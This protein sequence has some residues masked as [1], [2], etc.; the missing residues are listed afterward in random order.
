MPT[1]LLGGKTPFEL[2]HGKPPCYEYLRTFGCLCFVF[3]L[4]QGR[5]KL[6]PRAKACIFLGYAFGKKAYRVMD[7]NTH[8]FFE[9]KDVVFHENI[10]P[11]DK[12]TPE[13]SGVLFPFHKVADDD[14]VTLLQQPDS[15]SIPLSSA[16]Q[17]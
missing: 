5:D 8:K 9:S 13:Q 16:M 3:T 7:L 14:G 1:K 2:L 11:F 15:D 17:G 10:F 12:H 4:K 6:Q